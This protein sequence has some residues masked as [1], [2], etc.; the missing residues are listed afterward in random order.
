TWSN[1]SSNLSMRSFGVPR[2]LYTPVHTTVP[3][4]APAISLQG[5]A[6]C[7]MLEDVP[8][9]IFNRFARP[10]T[11]RQRSDDFFDANFRHAPVISRH[12]ATHVVLGDDADQH[13]GVKVCILL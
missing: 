7:A 11:G 5:H 6:G 3:Q 10:T 9:G 2:P 8:A 12:A 1:D 4:Q 13:E